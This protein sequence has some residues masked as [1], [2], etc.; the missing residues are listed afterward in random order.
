MGSDAENRKTISEVYESLGRNGSRPPGGLSFPTGTALARDLGYPEAELA[1]LPP[2]VLESFVGAAAL[3]CEVDDPAPG[4]GW[5]VDLGCGAGVDSLVLARRGHRVVSLDA[6]P[7][8][9]RRLVSAAG[10]QSNHAVR[11]LLPTLPLATGF[12]S[13]VLLN[14]VANL[15]SDRTQLLAEVSRV[16]RPAGRLLIADLLALGEIP[17]EVRELPEAWAWCVAGAASPAVWKS[18]LA[19][20]GFFDLQIQILEEIQPL[21]RGLIRARKAD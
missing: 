16:L 5:V 14:G 2:E 20:A 21:G 8:M 9:L 19:E 17:A 1:A 3:A 4:S 6:S 15:V 12:A 13:W 11:A 10:G 18:D 7:A